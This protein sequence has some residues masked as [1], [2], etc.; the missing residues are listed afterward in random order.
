MSLK[1]FFYNL[2]RTT[3]IGQLHQ[4]FSKFGRMN[5]IKLRY[6]K[7]TGLPESYGFISVLQRSTLNKI[8]EHGHHEIDG[9]KIGLRFENPKLEQVYKSWQSRVRSNFYQGKIDEPVSGPIAP[10]FRVSGMGS[11][12]DMYFKITG[13]QFVPGEIQERN[14]FERSLKQSY[15]T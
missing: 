12:K 4:H 8:L 6:R 11:F 10:A 15:K 1:V 5:Q 2:P 13:D 14:N 9:T 3:G 7:D